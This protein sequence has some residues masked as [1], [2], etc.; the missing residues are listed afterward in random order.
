MRELRDMLQRG[1]LAVHVA[2]TVPPDWHGEGRVLDT[3]R[4][5]TADLRPP[6]GVRAQVAEGMNRVPV[7]LRRIV[8]RR[9]PVQ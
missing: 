4:V 7:T 6:A 3:V 2:A 8:E 5:V 1:E 9:L